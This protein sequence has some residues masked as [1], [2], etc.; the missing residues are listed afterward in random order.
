MLASC[1][2]H[3]EVKVEDSV[4]DTVSDTVKKTKYVLRHE[5]PITIVGKFISP[6]KTDT[7][8]FRHYSNKTHRYIDSLPVWGDDYELGDDI[9]WYYGNGIV[10]RVTTPDG[11]IVH[12]VND[13]MYVL[14]AIPL[15]DL[16]PKTD[17]LA[18]VWKCQDFSAI[19]E[20]YIVSVE[21]GQWDELG[22]FTVNYNAFP[23][24]LTDGIID[25]FLEKRNGQ[26]VYIDWG[27]YLQCEGEFPMSPLRNIL[28]KKNS[29]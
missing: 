1:Q 10:M 27:V 20:C 12:T 28:G 29:D 26:W 3:T 5:D 16:L 25:G 8:Q 22:S 19:R 17:A 23:D 21:N 15:P 24:T 11:R 13:A 2:P 4:S 18:V 9:D 14:R 6:D 7:L